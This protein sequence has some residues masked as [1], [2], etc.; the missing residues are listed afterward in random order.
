MTDGPTTLQTAHQ[1][2]RTILNSDESILYYPAW[3]SLPAAGVQ[4]DPEITGHRLRS[5]SALKRSDKPL[6]L[7]TCV[8]ALMQPCIS[9]ELAARTTIQLQVGGKGPR[10]EEMQSLLQ[11]SGYEFVADVTEKGEASIRGGIIDAWPPADDWPLRIEFMGPDVDSIRRFDPTTQKS[12]ERISTSLLSPASEQHLLAENDS[13][14]TTLIAH[15]PNEAVIVWQGYDSIVY[16]ADLNIIA[17]ARNRQMLEPLDRLR[18]LTAERGIRETLIGS[19]SHDTLNDLGFNPIERLPALA[20]NLMEPDLIEKKRREFVTALEE[21]ARSGTRVII[22]FDTDGALERFRNSHPADIWNSGIEAKLG[23]LSEGLS[24]ETG[25]AFALVSESDLYGRRKLGLTRYVP[26]TSRKPIQRTR[27]TRLSD[28]KTIQPGDLVVHL[29]HGIGKY[30]GLYGI[31]VDKQPQEVL[32]LEYADKAKLHVPVSQAHLLTRYV[33]AGRHKPKLHRLGTK[34]WIREKASAELSLQDMAA[35]ML[36]LQAERDALPGHAF[37]QDSPWQHSFEA[38][39]PYKETPDQEEAITAVKADME[40]E[41]PSDRLICGDAGYGKT[42]VAMRAA[43]KSVADGKQVCM[44]VPTT[45]L[46]QQHFFTFKERMAA[47]P[48]R[49]EMLS[50]FRTKGQCN[51]VLQG[52]AA[53]TVDIVIGTHSLIQPNVRFKDLGL[54]IVDEEQRFG[55]VHKEKLKKLRK[56]VD[57]LTMTATPIPRTLY[58]SLSGAKDLSTIETPPQE[59]L[60]VET[61]VT[62]NTDTIIRD[63]ILRELNREGQVFYLHN[64]VMTIEKVRERLVGLLPEARIEIGHGQMSSKELASVM[65]RFTRGEFDVLLSTTIVES[66]MDI[67]NANTI[68]IDRADRFGMADLYQLRGRV[69]R[70]S[71]KGYAYLLIPEHGRIDPTARKRIGAVKRY[72]GLGVG[73]KLALRDLEIRGAGNLLGTR[74]TGHIAAIGFGL[75]CQLLNRT[76]AHLKGEKVP[77]V[78]DVELKLDFIEL[79]PGSW[80]AD[81]SAVIPPDYVEDEQ[82]RIELYRKIAEATDPAQTSQL[83]DECHDRFGAIPDSLFRLLKLA[84][85]RIIAHRAGILAIETRETKL[86]MSNAAGYIMKKGRFPRLTTPT[87]NELLDE[88]IDTLRLMV[89]V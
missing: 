40:R 59:R 68:L 61:I 60:A 28:L 49:I 64:R 63:A 5:I 33:G 85:L 22:Y 20:P 75:Y 52:L 24:N 9:P 50:R 37:P 88:I 79:S 86:M 56:L 14:Q 83:G 51:V 46:A 89:N 82:H 81:N 18:E 35:S 1:D 23:V 87:A 15:L 65:R 76:I 74:Q 57:V 84:D 25:F 17:A 66:G 10:Y 72:S 71:R 13:E 58:M 44:V 67:P 26:S 43:F 34:R 78:I 12:V 30:L 19:S 70:S 31:V 36:Q 11:K 7:T 80:G 32:S 55:V 27:G 2:M 38:S 3:N 53:G 39:F 6:L 48:F 47:Y 45:V 77:P 42:E 4:F 29:Q 69:G 62:Q 21:K 8:Q 41:R 73:F 16:H 54:V